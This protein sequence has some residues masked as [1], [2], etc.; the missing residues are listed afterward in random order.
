MDEPKR[1][2]RPPK[3]RAEEA[4]LA[5]A[6]VADPPKP[7]D[8]RERLRELQAQYT[9]IERQ[10][11][12]ASSRRDLERVRLLAAEQHKVA[13]EMRNAETVARITQ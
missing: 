9:T 1:R 13:N 4:P 10:M 8:W 12:E 7:V 11:M 3:V 6:D 2:G 5:A